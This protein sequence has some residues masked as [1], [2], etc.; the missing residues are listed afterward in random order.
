M[1]VVAVDL[2][3]V[4]EVLTSAVPW[5]L[6]LLPLLDL[7]PG[8]HLAP[9]VQIELALLA[10]VQPPED[11]RRSVVRAQQ[12]PFRCWGGGGGGRESHLVAEEEVV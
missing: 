5:F 11:D 3:V 9:R 6:G 2:I 7:L 12:Q 10:D 1:V 4:V 8:Q